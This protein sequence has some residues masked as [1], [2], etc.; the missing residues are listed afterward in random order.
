[1]GTSFEKAPFYA[2]ISLKGTLL[3]LK[4]NKDHAA[5]RKYFSK[6]FTQNNLL[7]WEGTLKKGVRRAILGMKEKGRE[8]GKEVDVLKAVTEMSLKIMVELCFGEMGEEGGEKIPKANDGP[9]RAAIIDGVHSEVIFT[10]NGSKRKVLYLLRSLPLPLFIT[11]WIFQPS[12]KE[13]VQQ[14]KQNYLTKPDDFKNTILARAIGKNEEDTGL[15]D[16]ILVKEAKAFIVAGTDTTANAATYLFW[17]VLKHPEVKA[18]LQ[19]EVD[20]LPEDFSISQVQALPYLQLVITETLRIFQPERW[21][22]PTPEMKDSYMPFG[23]GA[24][25]CIGQQLAQMELALSAAMLFREF[26][27]VRIAPSMTEQDMIVEDHF[28]MSP[29]GHNFMVVL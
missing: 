22:N 18:K 12:V 6:A 21:E 7:E 23:I 4:G 15:P 10:E 3:C 26:H 28:A 17:V 16:G 19:E 14:L 20:S 5:R 13:S 29:K 25:V 8:E 9:T 11:R 2:Q 27:N 1:M 24:R